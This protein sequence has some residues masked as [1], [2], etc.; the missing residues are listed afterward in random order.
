MILREPNN[1]YMTCSPSQEPDPMSPGLLH[2][3][4]DAPPKCCWG[5]G[6]LKTKGKQGTKN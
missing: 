4:D 1:F 6:R 5:R 2:Y 3:S